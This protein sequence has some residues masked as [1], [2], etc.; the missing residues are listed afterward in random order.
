MRRAQRLHRS[1]TVLMIAVLAVVTMLSYMLS[2]GIAN[3]LWLWIGLVLAALAC[4][5]PLVSRRIALSSIGSIMYCFLLL[6]AL[7]CV[8][9][10][11]PYSCIWMLC[12]IPLVW[13]ACR[14]SLPMTITVGLGATL[15]VFTSAVTASSP[16]VTLLR[17]PMFV[18]GMML[19]IG[20]CV[21][22]WQGR[23][24]LFSDRAHQ[25][26]QSHEALA[27]AAGA[28]N[29][30]GAGVTGG[31]VGTAAHGIARVGE[32][33][34]HAFGHHEPVLI[35]V[36]TTKGAASSQ[37][38]DREE[39]LRKAHDLRSPL[40]SVIGYMELALKRGTIDE[41]SRADLHVAL[42][43]A[44]RLD[45]SIVEM[46]RSNERRAVADRGPTGA[47][48][49]NLTA[50]L[51][52]ELH[53]CEQQASMRRIRINSSLEPDLIITAD[54]L[55]LKS[56]FGNLLSNAVKY[57]QPGGSVY[58]SALRDGAMITIEVTDTGVGIPQAEL[59]RVRDPFVRA[60]NAEAVASG[61]GMGLHHCQTIVNRLHGTMDI[62]SEEGKG[63]VVTVSLPS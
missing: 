19:I 51:G 37:L 12:V 43:N 45:A 1:L 53:E 36:N 60:A 40:S 3:H 20:M 57:N 24:R 35:E 26:G 39:L 59:D 21:F 10:A 49:T 4:V 42:E 17:M 62:A 50:V 47:R 23:D 22:V 32:G 54:P 25:A 63:T 27:S 5:P 34:M 14:L 44:E 8:S 52:E 6:I 2:I 58:V 30:G 29:A 46:V 41:Q 13:A 61:T 38:S 18:G 16:S 9:F 11:M 31:S 33:V 56:L 48:R 55:Q 15:V 28:G 7:E